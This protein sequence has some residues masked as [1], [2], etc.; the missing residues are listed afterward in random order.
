MKKIIAFA[1]ALLLVVV[2][3]QALAVDWSASDKTNYASKNYYAIN[4]DAT[5]LIAA[6]QGGASPYDSEA[7]MNAAIAKGEAFADVSSAISATGTANAKGKTSGG[8]ENPESTI[9][10]IFWSGNVADGVSFNYV[11]G[12]TAGHTYTPPGTGDILTLS[13][14]TGSGTFKNASFNSDPVPE[15]CTVA[16]LALGLAAVGLKRKVA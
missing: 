5:S 9:T 8:F 1:S 12:S 4:G 10:L 7:E 14:F 3:A 13:G 2:S 11:T 16:L 15:P 6:L